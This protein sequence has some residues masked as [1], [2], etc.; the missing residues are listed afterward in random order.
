[1]VWIAMISGGWTM[2]KLT[3]PW[4]PVAAF[5]GFFLVLFI[6]FRVLNTEYFRGDPDQGGSAIPVRNEKTV[7]AHAYCAK[8]VIQRLGMNPDRAR[9]LP[10][11]TAWD[12][13]FNRYLVKAAV[14]DPDRTGRGKAYLCRLAEQEGSASG[15]W[16]V[17]S[18]EYLD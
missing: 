12:I 18:I 14:E 8:S 11:Y 16:V 6:V 9:A 13:G 17:Q 4:I 7:L 5:G 2:P 3:G 15:S 1:M 10:E